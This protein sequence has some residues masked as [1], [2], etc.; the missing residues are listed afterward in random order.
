MKIY[1]ISISEPAIKQ[2]KKLPKDVKIKI[3]AAISSF[4]IEPR[5]F[6][7]KKLSGSE[8]T[9]RIRIGNYRII[10]DIYEKEI[11]IKVLKVGHRKDIY[12]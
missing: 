3:I 6:G 5:P 1:L 12:N 9:Y 4:E 7:C 2:I 11:L 8:N 10:Y